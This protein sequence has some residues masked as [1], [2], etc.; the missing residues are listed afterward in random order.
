MGGNGSP[1]GREEKRVPS[2]R[3]LVRYF[4]TLISIFPNPSTQVPVGC[5]FPKGSVHEAALGLSGL[6]VMKKKEKAP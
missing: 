1:G 6:G 2:R 5:S 3:P 4:L